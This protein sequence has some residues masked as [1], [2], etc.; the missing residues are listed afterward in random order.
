LLK[1]DPDWNTGRLDE[2]LD[3]GRTKTIVLKNPVPVHI[4]Y[5]TAWA[6]SDGT[7]YFGK[8]I[9]NRDKQLIRAL[10]KDSR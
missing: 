8:D 1:D 6:D 7:V 9:Y 4:V 3:N 2:A 10:K 5:F